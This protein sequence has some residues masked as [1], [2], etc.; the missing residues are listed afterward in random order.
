MGHVLQ[1]PAATTDIFDRKMGQ[2]V[3]VSEAT[4]LG[5]INENQEQFPAMIV[6]TKTSL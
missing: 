5:V 3:K 1:C 6:L 4:K 2:K